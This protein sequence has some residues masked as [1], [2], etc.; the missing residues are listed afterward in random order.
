MN[1]T[2][3]EEYL[4]RYIERLALRVNKKQVINNKYIF[5][6]VIVFL[7]GVALTILAYSSINKTIG[8]ITLLSSL[9]AFFTTIYFHNKVIKSIEKH[10]AWIIIK[11][12]NIARLNLDW[13]KIPES[14]IK[15]LQNNHPFATDIDIIGKNS[16]YRLID[17][18]V[19]ENGSQKLL[20]MLTNLNPDI[21]QS[22]NI[23]HAIQ[24]CEIIS[25]VDSLVINLVFSIK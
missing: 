23:P 24:A 15:N 13:D 16:I 4:K 17:T 19:S 8:T 18:S 9:T 21:N 14:H 11:G 22:I 10:T 25:F 5:L 6:R 7:L 3:K 1:K 2:E 12:E 20:D